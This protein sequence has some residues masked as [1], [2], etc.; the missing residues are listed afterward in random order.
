MEEATINPQ[1]MRMVVE[2]GNAYHHYMT[3]VTTNF[4]QISY[5]V[6][7][8]QQQTAD[9]FFSRHVKICVCHGSWAKEERM[10]WE[11]HHKRGKHKETSRLDIVLNQRREQMITYTAY[12]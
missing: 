6:F 3:E 7:D 10:C 2:D 9:V 8:M 11:A 1:T 4:K 12:V 5:K